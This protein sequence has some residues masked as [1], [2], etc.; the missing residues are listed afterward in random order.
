LDDVAGWVE[1]SDTVRRPGKSKAVMTTVQLSTS[2]HLGL[3]VSLVPQPNGACFAGVKHDLPPSTLSTAKGLTVAV[4]ARGG[5]SN[6]KVVLTLAGVP[7]STCSYQALFKVMPVEG[8]ADVELVTLPW[9]A[10]SPVARGKALD[11]TTAPALA[12][13]SIDTLGV[14][15]Y[16]GVYENE[17]QQG[18]GLLEIHF[19]SAL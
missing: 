18:V 6:W 7:T 14:Q 19:I 12:P 10:F 5:I 4:K 3:F 9:S 1:S 13:G 2:A 15:A 17:Q 11:P 8:D 16:G